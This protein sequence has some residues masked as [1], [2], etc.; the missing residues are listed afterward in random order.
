MCTMLSPA[1]PPSDFRIS[2]IHVLYIVNLVSK[3]ACH[4][5]VR[6]KRK[7][8]AKFVQRNVCF[9]YFRMPSM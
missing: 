3:T 9:I 6:C 1:I 5:M 2:K 7:L 4:D 8:H